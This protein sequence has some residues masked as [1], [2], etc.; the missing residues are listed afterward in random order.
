M[1]ALFIALSF[2]AVGRVCACDLSQRS[3][4]LSAARIQ[5]RHEQKTN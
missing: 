3:D 4:T 1:I 2:A 5:H